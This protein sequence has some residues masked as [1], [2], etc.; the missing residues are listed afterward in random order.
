MRLKP[1]TRDRFLA[2]LPPDS[3]ASQAMQNARPVPNYPAPGVYAYDVE[4]T[5]ADVQALLPIAEAHGLAVDQIRFTIELANR[6]RPS[7]RSRRQPDF[8]YLLPPEPTR[9]RKR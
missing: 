3:P 4:L 1:E 8:S 9:L 5:M 6:K 7:R 2:V